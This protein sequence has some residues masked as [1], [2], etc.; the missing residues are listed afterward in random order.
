M[1][2]GRAI[3]QRYESRTNILVTTFASED[4]KDAFE[5]I[6]FMPRYT[7]DGRA[8]TSGDAPSDIVRLLR[9]LRG[10]PSFEVEYDP[11][12]EYGRFPAE[13]VVDIACDNIKTTT[14]GVLDDGHE[15]YESVYLYTD[16]SKEG[17]LA[18]EVFEL[19][20]TRYLIVSYHDKVQPPNA[21]TVH[22]MLQRTRSYWLLWSERTHLPH[23]YADEVLRSALTLKLLQFDVT[24]AVVAAATTSLPETVGE[25]RNWDYRYCWIRDASMT[26]STVRRLGHPRMAGIFI[27]WMLRTVPTK[28]DN[29]Q[30]M[31]GLRGERDLTEEI[32]SHLSGYHGSS[33]VRI[34]NAA[35]DQEQH[36][37]YGILLDVVLQDVEARDR[38]PERLDQLW[39]RVRSVVRKVARR[40][41]E[42][43]RGIWEIRGEQR[44]FVFS[45]VLCWVAIDRALKIA[46]L[47]GKDCWIDEHAEL[48][49]EIH[50][51]ILE[52]GWNEEKG[53]FTQVYGGSDL[54][55][56]NLLLAQYG[57]VEASDPRF[58]STVAASEREL[59]RD[60][61]MYR[62]RNQDDFGEPSSAFTVCSFWMVKALAGI[63]RRADARVMFERLLA[64]ANPHGLYGE[65]LDFESKRHLGNFPQAYSHLAL[66]D[67]AMELDVEDDDEELLIEP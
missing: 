1:P 51:D 17:V 45:K 42:P 37:I 29:L 25:E 32:L 9:P 62:Y 23:K 7:W 38:T 53:A 8:G 15:V 57:F 66:I 10:K 46:K 40:W 47:L 4:G 56:S 16:L 55:A 3:G 67:C 65:D 49:E 27:D 20:E 21:N 28:D 24:G 41:R 34:G 30:I 43:D 50:A 5:V 35:Y 36:D 13:T 12:P 26:V 18:G 39:T 14:R 31:Y 48:A 64:Y 52:N 58:I 54:D 19:S 22:L 59:C 60:G 11:R 6:D 63:G 33:P 2:G 61:L 44:H